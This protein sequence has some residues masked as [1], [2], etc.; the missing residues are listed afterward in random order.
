MLP[1]P[2]LDDRTFEQL[3]QEAR[4]LIPTIFAEWTDENT[5]DPGMTLLE[6]L[7]WHVE[8]QQYQLNRISDSHDRKFL[9]L[10]GEMPRDVQP[11]STSVSISKSPYP[12]YIP[13]GTLLWVRDLPF[14]TIRP[15]TALPDFQ[16]RITLR[17]NNGVQL[18]E[19][20]MASG[21]T[22]IYPFGET[23]TRGASV[24]LTLE[25]ALPPSLP[26]SLWMELDGQ[27]PLHRI[28]ARYRQFTPS[29]QIEWSYWHTFTAE[30]RRGKSETLEGEQ[31]QEL[32]DEQ[33]NNQG[34][35]LTNRQELVSQ[36]EQASQKQQVSESQQEQD[37]AAI[38]EW[39][40]LPLERDE[41]YSLHQSGPIL[42][43]IP[44]DAVQVKEIKAT[45]I[46]GYYNDP[47][48]IRRL[49][50]NEVFARQGQTLCIS[51]CFDG[52]TSADG[53]EPLIVLEHGL[54]LQSELTVQFETEAGWIDQP[55]SDYMVNFT[56][57]LVSL[58]FQEGVQLPVGALSIRVIASSS[59]F[60]NKRLLGTGTGISGQ[61]YMLPVQPLLADTLQLQVGNWHAERQEMVW[62]D[63]ER[64]FDFD[65]SYED[66]LHYVIDQ[67][68]GVIRFSDSVY[69]AVPPRTVQPN[70]RII[71]Y[72]IGTGAAG[73][74]MAD[75][76]HELDYFNIPLQVTN[77]FPAYGGTEAETVQDALER[78]K[79]A[80]MQP[81]C[82]VTVAD[83]EQ[84]VWEI[85]GLR[86][87]RVKAISGFNPKWQQASK[88]A[89]GHIAIVVVP[90]SKE[91]EPHPSEGVIRTIKTHLEP[92]RLLT[93]TMHIIAPAYIKVTIRAILVV[94]PR[95]EGREEE[96]RQMLSEW[97][98]P[99]NSTINS[100]RQLEQGWSF[101]KS[102]HK[103]DV[104]NQLHQVAGVQY[105][106][107]LWLI[108]E[109]SQAY[110]DEGG[111]IHIPPNGLV[112]SGVHDIEFI[113]ATY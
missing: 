100:N 103:S 53:E 72:R 65:E 27:E 33:G 68:A 40:L 97:L 32:A 36:Q 98:Q 110:T 1:L 46:D 83:I 71:N 49:I 48:R 57:E 99:Y 38:G 14:E 51:V 37:M 70:I 30:D 22:V 8:M 84:R 15:F 87:V 91:A 76:I 54:F 16:Q 3:V 20:D 81:K 26:L 109:G 39:R 5:H 56:D 105:I 55:T 4:Q 107:D 73:N 58:Q 34:N 101:G 17:S 112:V 95:Y 78:A 19:E 80:M 86:L 43:S 62:Q 35:E 29:G 96:V 89:A 52:K 50:W 31:G 66:S 18:I 111:D 23:A 88:V 82:A 75:T 63:W 25:K 45:L 42:F 108:S 61:Q 106:Q 92:Y 13:Y 59:S 93:T 90:Y 47:P 79:G 10:L 44:K 77:L 94:H 74:V 104:F 69:G 85:P 41:T 11:A 102:V 12:M 2:N 21:R 64:V 24:T 7:A 9:R 28:P 67:E 60:A 6:M 113:V